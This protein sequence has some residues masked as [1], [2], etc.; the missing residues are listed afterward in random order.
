MDN[1]SVWASRIKANI[2]DTPDAFARTIILFF[3]LWK[4]WELFNAFKIIGIVKAKEKE[5]DKSVHDAD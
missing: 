1:L 4:L 5:A 2:L 3:K